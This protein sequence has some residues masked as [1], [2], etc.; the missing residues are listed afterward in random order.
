MSRPTGSIWWRAAWTGI[1][2]SSAHESATADTSAPSHRS[3][4]WSPCPPRGFRSSGW[5]V[6]TPGWTVR[7]RHDFFQDTASQNRHDWRRRDRGAHCPPPLPAALHPGPPGTL[8]RVRRRYCGGKEPGAPEFHQTVSR[9][10]PG[11]RNSPSGRRIG[12][13]PKRDISSGSRRSPRR[14]HRRSGRPVRSPG[15]TIPTALCS[16]T[17]SSPPSIKLTCWQ[18]TH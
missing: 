7:R 3:G 16:T 14:K 6:S 10:T 9:C 18:R 1:F 11:R 12:H 4:C 13:C 15:G 8:H 5:S 17:W 2:Q